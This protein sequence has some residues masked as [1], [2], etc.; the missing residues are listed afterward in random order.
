MTSSQVA[1][2]IKAIC[3]L[4]TVFMLFE[5]VFFCRPVMQ[6]FFYNEMPIQQILSNW[7]ILFIFEFL[8]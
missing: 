3:D 6:C 5:I 4:F 8:M 2:E 1:H 7:K